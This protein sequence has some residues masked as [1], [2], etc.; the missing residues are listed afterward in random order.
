VR[1][2]MEQ[3]SPALTDRGGFTTELRLR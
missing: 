2:I 3:R 1:V